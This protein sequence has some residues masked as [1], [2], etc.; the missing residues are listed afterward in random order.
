ML[1]LCIVHLHAQKMTC[2]YLPL[3]QVQLRN[4]VDGLEGKLDALVS[5]GGANF[6]VWPGLC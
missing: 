5:E 1:Y 4:V 6:T 3:M 2:T